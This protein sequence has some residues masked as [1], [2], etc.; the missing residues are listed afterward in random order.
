MDTARSAVQDTAPAVTLVEVEAQAQEGLVPIDHNVELLLAIKEFNTLRKQKADID[1]KMDVIKR[2]LG[3]TL[4][5]NHLQAFTK[6]G[7]AI[8]RL[9]NVEVRTV[10]SKLLKEKHPKIWLAFLKITQSKRVWIDKL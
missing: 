7:K 4:E 2:S 9:S 8:V 1:V 5:E 10:D 6:G 3:A